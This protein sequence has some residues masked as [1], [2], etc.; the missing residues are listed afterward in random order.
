MSETLFDALAT[1][2]DCLLAFNFLSKFGTKIGLSEK[3]KYLSLLADNSSANKEI[4][5]KIQ[6][7]KLKAFQPEYKDNK[8]TFTQFKP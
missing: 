4:W 3:T 8:I 6:N 5:S 1:I 2:P 7:G